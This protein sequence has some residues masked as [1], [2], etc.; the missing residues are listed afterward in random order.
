MERNQ[1][2]SGQLIVPVR[3]RDFSRAEYRELMSTPEIIDGFADFLHGVQGFMRIIEIFTQAAE[4]RR[5]GSGG[6]HGAS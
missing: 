1:A 3:E 5:Y 6:D 2:L 4:R